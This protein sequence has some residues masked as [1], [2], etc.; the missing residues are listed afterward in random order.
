MAAPIY[1][2]IVK[3]K[4]SEMLGLHHL[5]SPIKQRIFPLVD[6]AA[7]SK[8]KDKADAI[9]YV[10]RNVKGLSRY[11]NGFSNV[12]LDS[13]EMDT[14]IRV[15]KGH[16][17]LHEAASLLQE[18]GIRV[19]PVVGLSRDESHFDA[20]KSIAKKNG[21]K[22]VS[23][24]L[25]DYDLDTPSESAIR[26][27]KLMQG[28]LRDFQ[29]YLLYDFRDVFGKDSA[30]LASRAAAITAKLN[31]I[32]PI[33]TIVAGCGIPE[34]MAQAV[35][36]RSAGYIPR[37]EIEIWLQYQKTVTSGHPIIPGD[38][39]TVTPD[40]AELDWR[41]IRKTAGP[42]IVYTLEDQWFVIRGGA[43][44]SHPLGHAQYFELAKSVTRLPEY[45][46][47]KFSYGDQY[48]SEKSRKQ[49]KCGSAGTWITAC[50]N[51]HITLTVH[52]LDGVVN[53]QPY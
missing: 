46:G 51:R 27:I 22:I 7:P 5:E 10:E 26:L 3:S 49:G 17:P 32:Q 14:G 23:V 4:Q 35:P 11:L 2:P 44:E 34:R 48:I 33:A 41:I 19:I 9:K 8:E 6:L 30:A 39:T 13:S 53:P 36:S 25:D 47:G 50:V 45:P 29:I 52:T 24:R 42:K 16:H 20:A 38:Y 18:A 37:D 43:F 31:D 40:H 1:V 12:M 21:E 28:T 15:A